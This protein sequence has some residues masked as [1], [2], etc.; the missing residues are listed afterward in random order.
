MSLCEC[1]HMGGRE[2]RWGKA[3]RSGGK[4]KEARSRWRDGDGVGVYSLSERRLVHVGQ[5]Q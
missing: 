3:G 1:M 4:E 2:G 5:P